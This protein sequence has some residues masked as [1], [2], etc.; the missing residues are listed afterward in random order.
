MKY[1]LTVSIVLYKTNVAIVRQAIECVLESTLNLKLYL[2]DNSPTDALRSLKCDDRCEY[3]FNNANLGFG[4]AHNIIFRRVLT[5]SKYHLVLNPDVSFPQNTL[6]TLF[7]FMEKHPDVGLVL[8]KVLNFESELQ[9]VSKRLPAPLDLMIRRLNSGFF[10][11]LFRERLARYEMREKDY[12]EIF[13][14]PSLSGCFMFL[15]VDALEKVGFFDERYFMYMEDIDL[16]RRM[17]RQFRN[18]Y[19]PRV[20]I[21]HGHARDSY[22]TFKLFRIHAKSAI[23]YFNKWGWIM[24]HERSKINSSL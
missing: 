18:V 12:N 23:R 24:D 11:S 7:A 15:R 8:P 17:Y 10:T 13:A 16:S 5:E 22:K 19:Y 3:I 1:D 21:R 2:I 6:E 9:Y 14:A 4:K 20:I